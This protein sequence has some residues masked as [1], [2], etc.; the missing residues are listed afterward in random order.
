MCPWNSTF[1]ADPLDRPPFGKYRDLT[2]RT[3]SIVKSWLRPWTEQLR[4]HIRHPSPGD[5]RGFQTGRHIAK[6]ATSWMIS[7]GLVTSVGRNLG[8]FFRMYWWL[9]VR[10]I[11]QPWCCLWCRQ[12]ACMLSFHSP[13]AHIRFSSNNI[14]ALL[15][16]LSRLPSTSSWFQRSW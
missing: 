15:R 11:R 8:D 12:S 5:V 1:A 9:I 3:P 14:A 16:H 4:V 13:V 6:W 10:N 2:L 7:C